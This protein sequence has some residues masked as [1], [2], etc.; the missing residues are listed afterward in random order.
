MRLNYFKKVMVI[1]LKYMYLLGL[2]GNN[3][4]FISTPPKAIFINYLNILT[5]FFKY[6]DFK[7]AVCIHMSKKDSFE[8]S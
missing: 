2:S 5:G 7:F 6:A 3:G 4:N 1:F 8:R